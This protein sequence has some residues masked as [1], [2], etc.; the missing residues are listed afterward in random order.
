MSWEIRQGHTLDVLRKMPECSVHCV[1][2]SPPYWGL[3]DYGL[4]SQIW[5]DPG[6][7]EHVWGDAL[8]AGS[9]GHAG[10][11]STLVGTQTAQSSKAATTQGTFCQRCPA[12]CGSLG[13][14][15]DPESYVRHLVQVFRE[16]KRVLRPEGTLWLN[17]G[18]S[19]AA[20]RGYQV[21]DSEHVNVGN[22][23]GMTVPAGLKP[24]DL[25]GIPWRVAFALQADGWYLRSE[26]IW[27]KPSC[28]PESVRDR[29][30]RS[31]ETIFLLAKAERYYFDQ[32]A[33]REPHVEASLARARRNR[34]GGKYRERDPAQHGALKAGNGYGPDGSGDVVCSPGG[35]NRRSVWR[36]N[37]EPLAEPHFAAFPRKLVEPCVLAGTSAHGCCSAC[38]SPWQR[39]IGGSKY[40]PPV[41]PAGVRRVDDSRGD[42][43]RKLSGAD[44]N[45]QVQRYT[46][47]WA[48][49]CRCEAG[50]PGP[51]PRAG[52]VCGQWHHRAG[53]AP[54]GS[55]LRGN[56]VKPQVCA[57][58][59]R[60]H[61][62]RRES[63]ECGGVGT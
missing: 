16:V 22:N 33:I 5:D 11:K 37:P 51:L 41:V 4:E 60:P 27:E 55:K 14:E 13:L 2:T 34:F 8:Y 18:D 63:L 45:A 44:Y 32:D 23:H 61:P 21:P 50:G 39:V 19:Y 7:C 40:T 38:G 56:R 52:P 12:W 46:L 42:K 35:R 43:T 28:M 6:G 26:I 1:V 15:P 17:L 3:R 31:H 53:C 62:S 47:G 49:T 48:P 20:N 30:T 25:C 36:I 54:V 58:S 9:R 24:K 10:D 59:N 29:V 57:I